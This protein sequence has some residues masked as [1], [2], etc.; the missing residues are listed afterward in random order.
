MGND[1]KRS[2]DSRGNNYQSSEEGTWNVQK[3]VTPRRLL[4]TTS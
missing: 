2:H 3:T 1:P 4:T